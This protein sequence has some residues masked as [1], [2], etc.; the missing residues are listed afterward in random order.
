MSYES[1]CPIPVYSLHK[2][3]PKQSGEHFQLFS[4]SLVNSLPL[5][6]N[7]KSPTR[8]R[9]LLK[10]NLP[11]INGKDFCSLWEMLRC[12]SVDPHIGGVFV[13]KIQNTSQNKMDSSKVKEVSGFRRL[14]W[15]FLTPF[16]ALAFPCFK[17]IWTYMIYIILGQTKNTKQHLQQ[18]SKLQSPYDIPVFWW[19][20][21]GSL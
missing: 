13:V 9:R 21:S 7:K 8:K 19:F 18:L 5:Q 17:N 4:V 1:L 2:S 12:A 14:V 20:F 6:T 10:L 15:L 16:G 11:G 3:V